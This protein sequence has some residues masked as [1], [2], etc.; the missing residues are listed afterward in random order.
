LYKKR[1]RLSKKIDMH[2]AYIH[3]VL[4]NIVLHDIVFRQ[5][6]KRGSEIDP[7]LTI[8]FKLKGRREP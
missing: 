5:H 2:T 6:E 7:H 8:N 3:K 4:T 1:L